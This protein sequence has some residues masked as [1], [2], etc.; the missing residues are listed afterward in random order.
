MS[1]ER[2][3]QLRRLYAD[4]LTARLKGDAGRLNEAFRTVPRETFLG[5][6]PWRIFTG[7]RYLDTPSDD[8]ALIYQDVVVALAAEQ[9]INNGQPSLHAQSLAALDPRPG[10]KVIHVGVGTGYY[11][12]ILAHLVG[13]QGRVEAYEIDEPLARRAATLLADLPNVT[14]H[15]RSGA[16]EPLPPSHAIYVNA[17]AT[18]PAAAWLDCLRQGG[19]LLFPL[20]P[21]KGWGG[22]LLV[23]AAPQGFQA[24][25]L[26]QAMF[27]A[28]QGLRDAERERKTRA[29]FA[30]GG[31]GKVRS[32]RRG[33]PPD[34]TCWLAWEECWLSTSDP[35]SR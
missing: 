26:T 19:R 4:L 16:V 1:E 22:M 5:P 21:D 6:G 34:G 24:R 11:T 23:T 3:A 20:A 8:P 10:D 12:A 7:D 27:I 25:I 28:C 29:A 2:L 9:G 32:L 15:N 33:T 18:H 30:R 31:A 35:A 17:G 13:P 14:I